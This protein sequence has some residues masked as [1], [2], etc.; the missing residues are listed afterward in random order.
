VGGCENVNKFAKAVVGIPKPGVGIP[1]PGVGTPKSG[2]GNGKSGVGIQKAGV[3]LEKSGV[4]FGKPGV[5]LGKSGVGDGKSDTGTANPDAGFR[6]PDDSYTSPDAR[7]RVPDAGRADAPSGVKLS[8]VWPPRYCESSGKSIFCSRKSREM[9]MKE[10]F[11]EVVEEVKNLSTE[12]KLE[13]Q[14]LIEK[15][16][17][18]EKRQQI[19]E[20]HQASLKELDEGQLVFSSDVNMLKGMLND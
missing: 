14:A 15:Y 11:A 4:G 12:E 2:V 19:L 5:G 16:L 7:R 6:N 1:K 9:K 13:L 18:E 20:N 17:A 10:S 8:G 3:G